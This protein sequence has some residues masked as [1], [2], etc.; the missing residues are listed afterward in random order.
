MPGTVM[1]VKVVKRYD[2]ATYLANAWGSYI[3]CQS[4]NRPLNRKTNC[5]R[6]AGFNYYLDFHLPLPETRGKIG[7]KLYWSVNKTKIVLLL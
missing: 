2:G 7:Q 4:N 6:T 1:S 5:L 3:L